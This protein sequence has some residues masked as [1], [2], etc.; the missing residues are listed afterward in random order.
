MIM[1]KRVLALIMIMAMAISSVGVYSNTTDAATKKKVTIKVGQK[2]KVKVKGTGYSWKSANKKVATVKKGVI[3]GKKPGKTTVTAK[4][5]KRVYKITVTVT[6]K[7]ENKTTN[8][9]IVQEPIVTNTPAVD[10]VATPEPTTEVTATPEPTETPISK[11]ILEAGIEVKKTPYNNGFIDGVLC[12]VKS[13]TPNT[14]IRAVKVS[15]TPKECSEV[16]YL[17][18]LTDTPQYFVLTKDTDNIE[19]SVDEE[20]AK[21]Y[22]Y[23]TTYNACNAEVKCFDDDNSLSI[24]YKITRPAPLSLLYYANIV[25]LAYMGDEL[26]GA[27]MFNIDTRTQ[28][29]NYGDDILELNGSFSGP[30]REVQDPNDPKQT[31]KEKLFDRCE[32][33]THFVRRT[34]K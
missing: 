26:T 15:V 22:N 12:E 11:E 28:W 13:T 6:K 7:K 20:A 17:Y 33:R 16:D 30:Y 8:A 31:I 9:P 23:F 5:K 34:Y 29:T 27:Y 2:T 32:V 24:H 14:T 25:V 1:K 21:E 18:N 4:N 3:T 10:V 19:F